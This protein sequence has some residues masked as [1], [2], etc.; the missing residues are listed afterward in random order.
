MAIE[1]DFFAVC[2]SGGRIR[3]PKFKFS[4]KFPI[5]LHVI[6]KLQ[7]KEI[8]NLIESD[9]QNYFNRK[10]VELC[11]EILVLALSVSFI[12]GYTWETFVVDVLY[13]VHCSNQHRTVVGKSQKKIV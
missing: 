9:A 13:N 12:P 11:C 7:I 6:L 5:G 1:V 3:L 2:T 4:A 8:Q 10:F